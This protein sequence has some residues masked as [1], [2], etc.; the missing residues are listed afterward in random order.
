MQI[1]LERAD[2]VIFRDLHPLRCCWRVLRRCVRD[3]GRTR[4]DLAPDCPE[5]LPP[6]VFLWWILTFRHRR[7]PEI[8]QR[9][10]E[11]APS[12]AIHILQTPSDVA[13]WTSS[14]QA[15]LT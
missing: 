10:T 6:P 7:S 13:R 2:T 9:L 3:F 4:F 1:R 8:R 5:K 14:P 11:L 12:P 15:N